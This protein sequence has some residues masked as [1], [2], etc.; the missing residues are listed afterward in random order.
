MAAVY[1]RPR[2]G[3]KIGRTVHQRFRPSSQRRH[4]TSLGEQPRIWELIGAPIRRFLAA[5]DGSPLGEHAVAVARALAQQSGGE[6]LRVHVDTGGPMQRLPGVEIVRC[7]ESWEADL[8]VMGRHSCS[9]EL[10]RLLGTTS[11]AVVRR[12]A[13]LSLLVT[14]EVQ[15]VRSAT[16][17]VDGSIRGLGIVSPATAFLDLT[18]AR[19]SAICVLPGSR[20]AGGDGDW[21][22][23]RVERVSGIAGKLRLAS[24]Q[25]DTLVQ[26]GD[27]VREIIKTVLDTASDLLVLGVRRGGQ[28]GD[29]GS[30]YVGRE[31]LRS[32]PCAVLTVPI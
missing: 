3:G 31:L 10:P 21:V 1:P 12:R 17:A 32:A 11:D 14:L 16:I 24:G 29:S 27:P 26:W 28:R 13:G 4:D 20:S 9:P 19:A 22:D 30:G 23:P 18:L 6:F 25:C 8:V 2:G 15:S 5:S 7:G